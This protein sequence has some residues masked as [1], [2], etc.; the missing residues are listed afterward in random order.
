[1][2]EHETL[3]PIDGIFTDIGEAEI[4]PPKWV[5]TDLLPTGLVFV[6]A[7]PKAGKSTLEMAMTLLV[8]GLPCKALPDSLSQV[9]QHGSVLGFS[10][11][12]TAGELRHMCKVG[13]LCDP[14][15]D[16]RILIADDPW[17]FRL[18]DADGPTKLLFWLNERRPKLCFLDPLRDFHNLEEK[19]SGGMNRILR[20]I[21]KWAKENDSCML[22]V[23]H[24][25]KKDGEESYNANDLR[26]TGAIFGIADGVL[27][28]TKKTA[29]LVTINATF[30]R[31]AS[32]ERTIKIA[33]YEYATE[34]GSE[35]LGDV[36]EQV[37]LL[38]RGGASGSEAI[39]KQL[40]ITK[41]R[42]EQAIAALK[43]NGVK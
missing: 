39:A 33:S 27:M 10:Y 9:P 31:A 1:M 22:V 18:D 21:Q 34:G 28:L 20:P 40:K 25:K 4:I 15:N 7:P 29:G 14:P 17:L 6:G 42:V 30:K 26:G 32:W 8:S 2:T 16:R 41:Q 36:E 19:D 35:R 38:L 13:L 11:E 24:T 3:E 12:A 23:H 5:I 37:A 43:R